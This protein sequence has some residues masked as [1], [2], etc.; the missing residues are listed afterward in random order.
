MG[1]LI[2]GFKTAGDGILPIY[3]KY[4]YLPSGD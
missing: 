3:L 1:A 2:Y 4:K